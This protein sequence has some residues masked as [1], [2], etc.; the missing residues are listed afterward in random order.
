MDDAVKSTLNHRVSKVSTPPIAAVRAWVAGRCF[1][2]TVPLLDLAQAVPSYPPPESLRA[3]VADKANDPASYFYTDITGLAELRNATAAH[4]SRRYGAH[5][6]HHH[7]AITAGCNQA[8]CVATLALAGSGDAIVIP[9]P[10]YF[11]HDM[12]LT[13]QNIRPVYVPF[14]DTA[15]GVPNLAAI[16]ARLTAETRAIAIVTPNNPTGAVYPRDWL[17]ELFGI[18][19]HR[20]IALIIDETYKDFHGES[21]PPHDLFNEPGWEQTVVQLYSFSKAYSLTGMRVGSIVAGTALMEQITKILDCLQICAPRIGQLAALF[22]LQHLDAWRTAQSARIAA[23][24]DA[25]RRAFQD[26]RLHYRLISSGAFFGYVRHPF[27]GQEAYAV[28][29][30][31]ADDHDILCLPGSMFGADQEAYL[32]FAFANLDAGRFADLVARLLASQTAK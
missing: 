26:D 20:G 25:F 27:T 15:A 13:M 16:E 28:A 18:A 8:F 19:K 10:Y 7:V 29:K 9:L 1:S 24:A 12:W 5:I 4:M 11:N 14:N 21:S 30:R 22:G 17:R 6:D 23:Q 31:L 32:R 3:H 2:D